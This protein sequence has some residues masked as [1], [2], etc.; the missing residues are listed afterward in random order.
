MASITRYNPFGEVVSLREA[1][2][3]LFEDSVITPRFTNGSSR[4]VA[5]NLY[6]TAEGFIL[7]LPMPGANAANVEI[8]VQQDVVHLKWET[9]VQVPEGATVHLHG[10]QSG[11]Y[12]Q[13][14]TVPA[15]I[16]AERVEA[17]YADG[18]LTVQ[19]PKAE[20]AKARTIKV[21]AR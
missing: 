12:Q 15:P 10:F 13:S 8:T 1:M 7:Q 21:N 20:H 6:E 17:Q 11:Q 4:G 16:N 2:D 18:V 14:I 3:R 9:K 19:L 5:A